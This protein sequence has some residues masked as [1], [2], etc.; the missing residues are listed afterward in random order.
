MWLCRLGGRAAERCDLL[1]PGPG[2]RPKGSS[3]QDHRI[4]SRR[5]YRLGQ[6]RIFMFK[7]FT[8]VQD[9]VQI[10]YVS[11]SLALVTLFL[12]YSVVA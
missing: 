11:A 12:I 3:R 5:I 4:Q 6:M 8:K 1:L 9:A 2:R 7:A 10:E